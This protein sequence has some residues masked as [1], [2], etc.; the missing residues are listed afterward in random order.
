M[1]P[2]EKLARAASRVGGLPVRIL[3]AAERA[4]EA[5]RREAETL[6]AEAST[7]KGKK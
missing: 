5:R 1:M 3:E 6:A 2:E 4:A 7:R